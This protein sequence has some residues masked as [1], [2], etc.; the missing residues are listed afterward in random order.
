MS[1]EKDI[2][3]NI[4]ITIGLS[5]CLNGNMVRHNGG[6]KKNHFITEILG[7]YFKFILFC[8]EIEAGMGVP[9]E[10]VNLTGPIHSPKMIGEVSGIDWTRKV[11][12]ESR[13]QIKKLKKLNLCGYILKSGSPS[14]GLAKV[15][16]YSSDSGR[17]RKNAKGLFA[18]I[19]LKAY[20]FLPIDEETRIEDNRL[21][22]NFITR[23]LAY[24]R[25]QTIITK[26]NARNN[27]IT[28]HSNHK[29]LLM[30]HSVKYYRLLEQ[31]IAQI[32][33]YTPSDFIHEY[34]RLFMIALSYKTTVSKNVN[35]LRHIIKCFKKHL[36]Q[37]DKERLLGVIQEYHLENISLEVPLALVKRHIYELDISNLQ[38][39]A[40]LNPLPIESM[41]GNIV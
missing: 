37:N 36:S 27:I 2:N 8:P 10:P 13:K 39:Q 24:N 14:C 21:R 7:N 12:S 9:R 23:I 19:L 38:D 15:K 3:N 16:H 33:Q 4:E 29:Y 6:H 17:V 5:S 32:G 35:V 40:Y 20:P 18:D 11:N 25:L 26:S 22:G 41:L 34:S 1:A 28:F 30:A 31:L